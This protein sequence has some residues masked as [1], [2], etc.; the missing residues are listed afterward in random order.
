MTQVL[1]YSL[2]CWL[3]FMFFIVPAL[4]VDNLQF[5][6]A[7]S[8]PGSEFVA[9]QATEV[10]QDTSTICDYLIGIYKYLIGTVAIFAAVALIIGGVIWVTSAGSPGRIGTA[11]S[12]IASSLT[13]LAL[14][15]GAFLLLATINPELVICRYI[16]I[17]S[18]KNI[19][20]DQGKKSINN[21]KNTGGNGEPGCKWELGRVGL[22]YDQHQCAKGFVRQ[23]PAYCDGKLYV[24][25]SVKAITVSYVPKGGYY[26]C[27]A[28]NS[29]FDKKTFCQNKSEGDTCRINNG[30]GYCEEIN[31][32]NVCRPCKE[33]LNGWVKEGAT[34]Q[35]TEIAAKNLADKFKCY[36]SSYNFECPDKNGVC[37]D[38]ADYQ[39]AD[40]NMNAN[41]LTNIGKCWQVN[42]VLQGSVKEF[43]AQCRC[44]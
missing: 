26:C 24:E 18:I 1:K 36:R 38:L 30:W 31:G 40:C 3:C 34:P 20:I 7:V 22:A 10:S 35:D 39:V 23:D 11:K 32:T 12:W 21:S 41:G 13:G 42:G 37:G 5:T 2:L 29:V 33:K 27:C 4:A 6:P 9:G 25:S 15:L 17:D 8:I 14:A 19:A 16:S 43:F 44:Q 28:D